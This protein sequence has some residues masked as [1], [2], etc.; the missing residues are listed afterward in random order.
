MNFFSVAHRVGL[1][2]IDKLLQLMAYLI[3]LRVFESIL[4]SV[5]WL[6]VIIVPCI[7]NI[8]YKFF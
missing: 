3:R 5:S 7:F 6:K 1:K 4:A 8:Q 2:L